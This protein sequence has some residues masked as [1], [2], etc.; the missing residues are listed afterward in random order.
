MPVTW[1]DFQPTPEANTAAPPVGAP[2]GNYKGSN[3]NDTF[4]L[5][6][7]V[8]RNLGDTTLKIATGG[9]DNPFTPES[10]AGTMALQNSAAVNIFGGIVDFVK[11][12]IPVGAIIPFSGSTP[13]LTL[14]QAASL[15]GPYGLAICDGRIV[16]NWQTPDLRGQF[17]RGWDI[18]NTPGGYAGELDTN[19]RVTSN[20]GVHGHGGVTLGHTLTTGEMP[21]HTHPV[22]WTGH[23]PDD[24]AGGG[25]LESTNTVAAVAGNPND[26]SIGSTGGG[27]SHSH[28]IANDGVH[29]HTVN[30]TPPCFI[31]VYLQRVPT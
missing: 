1:R 10:V 12:G 23:Q 29:T 21:A 3:V 19:A 2:E 30:T 24:N 22:T 18:N 28:G 13:A 27:G 16:N 14:T 8:I 9:D 4:R 26:I 17:L 5:D 6:K 15:L 11:G 31:L 25:R 20:E 7:S